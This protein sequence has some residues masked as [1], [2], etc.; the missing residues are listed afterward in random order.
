MIKKF[1]HLA[2]TLSLTPFLV[3]CVAAEKELKGLD[4]RMRTIDSRVVEM[5]RTVTALKNQSGGQAEMGVQLDQMKNRMLQVEGRID[6]G[7]QQSRRFSDEQTA[8]RDE[9]NTRFADLDTNVETLTTQS[10]ELTKIMGELI[11]QMAAVQTSFKK[12][13]EERAK[14]AAE[15]AAAAAKAAEEAQRQAEKA[16]QPRVIEPAKQKKKVEAAAPASTQTAAAR[17]ETKPEPTAPPVKKTDNIYDK[18]LKAFKAKKYKEAYNAFLDYL[19]KHPKGILAANSRFWLGECLYQQKEYELAILEYQKVIADFPSDKK[20]PA[21]LLKQGI[22]FEK[23][24]EKETAK[25]VYNKLL[26]DYPKSEQ[27]PTA[28]KKLAQLK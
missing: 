26:T 8:M 18:G 19:E 24:D 16:T 2:L 4:L 15:Q 13:Q 27:A 22:S 14:L 6:E 10:T 25:I 11:E 7:I 1:T 9:V 12:L 17:P 23:L 21:A 28:K 20:A 3:Q 5:D